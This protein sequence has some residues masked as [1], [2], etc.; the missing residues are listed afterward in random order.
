MVTKEK[1]IKANL[2]SYDKVWATPRSDPN[3]AY[4]LFEDQPAINRG[5]KVKLKI[6][7]KKIEQNSISMVFLV[8]GII[9]QDTSDKNNEKKGAHK[10]NLN[11]FT[12]LKDSFKKSLIASLK[13]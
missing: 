9:L 7:N 12:G 2:I 11:L 5:Y 13:G 6:T 8:K 4:F 10:Y 3:K 1:I